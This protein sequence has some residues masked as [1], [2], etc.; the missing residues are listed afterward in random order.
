MDTDPVASHPLHLMT[1][2]YKFP[3]LQLL[4]D[5][6]SV[7][8]ASTL[9]FTKGAKSSH[10]FSDMPEVRFGGG[11]AVGVPRRTARGEEPTC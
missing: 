2:P 8:H 4:V 10:M 6:D 3:P 9:D 11:T 5:T 1:R 7:A